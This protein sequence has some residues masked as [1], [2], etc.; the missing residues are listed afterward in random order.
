[1]D[2]F[3]WCLRPLLRQGYLQPPGQDTDAERV[4]ASG[5]CVCK[6]LKILAR[7]SA[8]TRVLKG[9]VH[10]ARVH[11]RDTQLPEAC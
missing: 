6:V 9:Y 3:S 8:R 2:V 10:V 4:S 1:M 5:T 11:T 7:R